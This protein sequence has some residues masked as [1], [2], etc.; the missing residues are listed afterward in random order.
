MVVGWPLHMIQAQCVE[1]DGIMK[2]MVAT[3]RWE[4]SLM[5]CNVGQGKNTLCELPQSDYYQQWLH[6]Q[7][8][9]MLYEYMKDYHN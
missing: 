2:S 7:L 6:S 8:S 5:C 3:T 9:R 4:V 1:S